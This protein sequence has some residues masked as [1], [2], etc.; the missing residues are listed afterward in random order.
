[1]T[2]VPGSITDQPHCGWECYCWE[3]C[4]LRPRE[5]ESQRPV[6]P[7]FGQQGYRLCGSQEQPIL[8]PESVT[9]I[10]SCLPTWPFSSA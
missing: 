5:K 9:L 10:Q 2:L 8:K 6:C 4:F 3:L 7:E 1:M